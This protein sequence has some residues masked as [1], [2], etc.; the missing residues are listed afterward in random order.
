MKMPQLLKR[1]Q[2]VLQQFSAQI[3]AFFEKKGLCGD[4]GIFISVSVSF[5]KK[6][7][8]HLSERSASI[9]WALCNS[10]GRGAL[11]A[12][13]YGFWWKIKMPVFDNR[14]NARLYKNSVRKCWKKFLTFCTVLSL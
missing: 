14:K 4:R 5:S 13:V 1:S 9:L 12:A 8:G 10:K 2:T 7:K 6:R 3:L 11:T